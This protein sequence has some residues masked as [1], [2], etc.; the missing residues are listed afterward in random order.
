MQFA[1]AVL[2]LEGRRLAC[3]MQ[4]ARL[5]WS[6][7]RGPLVV[8]FRAFFFVFIAAMQIV[9]SSEPAELPLLSQEMVQ[10]EF[11]PSVA[12]IV[13]RDQ[14]RGHPECVCLEFGSNGC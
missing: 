9:I 12:Q 3:R 7:R 4:E 10:Y 6:T 8:A 13:S 2:E 5:A 11:E 14:G 1:S